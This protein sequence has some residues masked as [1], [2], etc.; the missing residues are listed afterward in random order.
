[1]TH[2]RENAQVSGNSGMSGSDIGGWAILAAIVF[3]V[4]GGAFY[5]WTGMAQTTVADN[6]PAAISSPMAPKR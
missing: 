3:G 6:G 4:V 2:D 5:W 1:M